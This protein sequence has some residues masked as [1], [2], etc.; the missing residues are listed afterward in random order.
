MKIYAPEALADAFEVALEDRLDGKSLAEAYREKQGGS[1]SSK[2]SAAARPDGPYWSG[3]HFDG[4]PQELARLVDGLA[5]T[6]ADDRRVWREVTCG[7]CDFFMGSAA[8]KQLR[9]PA[10]VRL[11]A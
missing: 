6:P 10:A 1:G 4:N 3:D 8:G 7:L 11:S 2:T 9:G 5:H